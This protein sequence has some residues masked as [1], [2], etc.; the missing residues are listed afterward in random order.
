MGYCLHFTDEETEA[1]SSWA[2]AQGHSEGGI[3]PQSRR[4][5]PLDPGGA[6]AQGLLAREWHPIS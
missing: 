3:H 2:V 5:L 1:Q 4:P 6:G